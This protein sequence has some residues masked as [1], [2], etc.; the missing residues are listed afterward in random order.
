M[1]EENSLSGPLID[2][3]NQLG[4]NVVVGVQLDSIVDHMK[5]FFAVDYALPGKGGELCVGSQLFHLFLLREHSSLGRENW[6]KAELLVK[7]LCI[8]KVYL[9]SLVLKG[10]NSSNLYPY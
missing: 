10:S 9:K 7:S 3:V 6:V 2:H 8:S 1:D 5:V 4:F